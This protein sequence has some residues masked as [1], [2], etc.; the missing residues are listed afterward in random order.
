MYKK[1]PQSLLIVDCENTKCVSTKV[2]LI[3]LISILTKFKYFGKNL[4]VILVM[5]L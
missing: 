3:S 2:I 5:L 1:I 4:I